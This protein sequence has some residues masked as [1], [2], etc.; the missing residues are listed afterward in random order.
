MSRN[1]VVL[2]AE[3]VSSYVCA[4]R[5]DPSELPALIQTAHAALASLGAEPSVQP[6][7]AKASAAEVRKSITP[8][9]LISFIDGRSYKM[10]KRHLTT[11]GE[12]V[13]SYKQRFG[14]PA[15]YPTTAPNY[16]AVRSAKAKAIGLGKSR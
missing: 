8:D 2:T 11:H 14:L 4:N 1:I 3:I 10:L 9:G 7:V 15:N 6:V 12:T 5:V 16:S 13:E